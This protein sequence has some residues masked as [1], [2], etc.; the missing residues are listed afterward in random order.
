MFTNPPTVRNKSRSYVI[1]VLMAQYFENIR[2][3]ETAIAAE[4]YEE[5]DY[6]SKQ[7]MTRQIFPNGKTINLKI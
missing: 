5:Y 1:P 4:Y 6:V 3:Y 7:L 2:L